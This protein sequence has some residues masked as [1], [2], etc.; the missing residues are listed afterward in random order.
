[1]LKG[2]SAKIEII[3]VIQYIYMFKFLHFYKFYK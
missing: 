2:F 3:I 1:M